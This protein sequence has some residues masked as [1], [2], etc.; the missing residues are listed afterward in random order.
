[1]TLIIIL[2]V[3]AAIVA[4]VVGMYN[5]LV[6]G[7]NRVRNAWSQID[8]QLQR[9]F[10]LLPN[11]VETVKG[12]M[13]HEED[14]LTKVT[15]L[16]TSWANATTVEQKV[17][18]DNQ[19]SGA[20]KTIMAV[21][22]NYPDLKANTNF[23]ELQNDLKDT[24]NKV[25][26]SRQFYNDTVTKYNDKVMMMPTSIVAGIFHFKEEPLYK[27]ETEEARQAVKVSF[28]DDKKAE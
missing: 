13:K 12:Y 10:D 27:V 6:Q 20:L 28:N 7:R 24:E 19:L 17:E 5:G 15:E 21:S 22:E 3:L 25:S 1:M 18:L 4:W 11:L 23:L 26:Y 2:V 14:T 9:R 8:V 16:R